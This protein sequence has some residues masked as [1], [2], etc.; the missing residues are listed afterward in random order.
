MAGRT[1][2]QFANAG[3][4]LTDFIA[5]CLLT[6]LCAGCSPSCAV[7]ATAVLAETAEQ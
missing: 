6:V 5:A 3:W 7:S 2:E 4:W 1:K